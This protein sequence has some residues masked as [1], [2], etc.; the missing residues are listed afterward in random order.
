MARAG[1]AARRNEAAEAWPTC[2]PGDVIVVPT[3]RRAGRGRRHRPGALAGRGPAAVRP[4][5]RPAGAPTGHRGLPGRAPGARPDAD[6]AGVL[7]RGRRTPGVSSPRC[8]APGPTGWTLPRAG[9][10]G[11][12]TRRTRSSPRCAPGCAPIPA[13]AARTASSTPG[14]RSGPPAA[15]RDQHH[16]TAPGGQD[17]LHRAAVR[18]DLP[19]ARRAGLPGRA[20]RQSR[21]DRRGPPPGRIYGESDLLACSACGR[22]SGT[23]WGPRSSPVRVLRSCSRPVAT[24]RPRTPR[25]GSRT[26]SGTRWRARCGSGA[27]RG[28]RAPPRAASPRAS[29]TSGSPG[30]SHRWASGGT[31][32]SVLDG[33]ELTAGDFVRWCKQVMDF[34]GQLVAASPGTPLAQSARTAIDSMR[35]GVVAVTIAE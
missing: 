34:L 18:P 6:P 19:A 17:Q 3:G 32:R 27:A 4:D 33:S 11:R 16:P 21:G 26:P 14:G 10:R 35:R 30:R 25:R 24:R 12:S 23:G 28:G 31:L 9:R 1:A 7:A 5:D 20:G 22:A 29:P 13:T 15:R 2:V 8:C